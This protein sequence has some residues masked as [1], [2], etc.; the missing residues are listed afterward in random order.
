MRRVC[1]TAILLAE[2]VEED[3]SLELV[4]TLTTTITFGLIIFLCFVF[5]FLTTP[6][7]VVFTGTLAGVVSVV[8]VAALLLFLLPLPLP[9]PQLPLPSLLLFL[10]F[11]M[12]VV[13]AAVASSPHLPP[14]PSQRLR[15]LFF[16]VL[17]FLSS[18]PPSL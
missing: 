13:V 7:F 15:S 5:P 2:P 6:F 9:L 8:M 16:S 12:V 17:Y 3:S 11:V 4:P 1:G 18:Q 10:L 14:S